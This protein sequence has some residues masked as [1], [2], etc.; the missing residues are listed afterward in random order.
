VKIKANKKSDFLSVNIGGK[1]PIVFD[2]INK[3]AT[4][5][6]TDWEAEYEE[7]R[8]AE[9]EEWLMRKLQKDITS[10]LAREILKCTPT[11]QCGQC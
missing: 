1:I 5:H 3:E 10:D 6:N 4:T 2:R 8:E 9:A 7:D 11:N